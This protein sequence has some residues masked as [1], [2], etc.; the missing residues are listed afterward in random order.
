MKRLNMLSITSGLL[1]V[2]V[3]SG[4][5]PLTVGRQ[6]NNSQ[7]PQLPNN[8]FAAKL[9]PNAVIGSTPSRRA[10]FDQLT[11]ERRK[12]VMDQFA[13]IV[14]QA[15]EDHAQKV[16]A[17]KE[18]EQRDKKED[19]LDSAM[20]EEVLPSISVITDPGTD[21]IEPEDPPGTVFLDAV[22]LD[23]DGFT[24][25]FERKLANKFTPEYHVSAG[26]RSGTG[27]ATFQDRSDIQ[28]VQQVFPPI[29]PISYYRVKPLGFANGNGYIQ[30]DYLTLWNRDDGLDIGGDC[31][32]FL[33]ILG[34]LA[35][36]SASVILDG[37]KSHPLDNERAAVRVFAPASGGQFNTSPGAYKVDRVFTA[38]HEGTST[39]NS[40]LVP[41][42]PPVPAPAH[43]LLGLSRSKHATYTFNPDHVSVLPFGVVVAI[44]AA[45][46]AVCAVSDVETCASSVFLADTVV[47][48]CFVER[49][50]EQGGVF[51]ET[52]INVGEPRIPG[53]PGQ[54]INNSNF[55][56]TPELKNK[57]LR[58]FAFPQ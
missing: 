50:Q 37:L 55:I 30:I 51:A 16:K 13:V 31:T 40:A 19:Q 27:F 12:E 53:Q 48:S 38:A 18:K 17:K 1:L 3:C 33:T 43:V 2:M 21:P 5:A 34:G 24:E 8:P 29:P 36:F 44:Y 46:G 4:F 7:R 39:D 56:N 9:P 32:T 15:L 42:S 52:R 14:A 54:P 20:D 58:S 47:L 10:A 11:P 26:E 41:V 28:V 22:D 49:F 23:G 35:G 25:R 57:L 6:L 45:V